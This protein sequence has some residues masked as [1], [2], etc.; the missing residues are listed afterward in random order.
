VKTYGGDKVEGEIIAYIFFGSPSFSASLADRLRFLSLP[1]DISKKEDITRLAAEIKKREGGLHI[2]VRCLLSLLSSPFTHSFPL[3]Q[4]NNAGIA[5]PKTKELAD[6]EKLS[7]E[8]LTKKLFEEEQ[9]G[10]NDV[11]QTN[12]QSIYYVT[13]AFLPL[14]EAFTFGKDPAGRAIYEK[15]QSVVC[16]FFLHFLL[17]LCLSVDEADSHPFFSSP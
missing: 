10:W 2:L 8:E 11:F 6:K 15:Y 16:V 13:L 9:Q 1:G 5:G 7:T 3:R 17:P 4:F 14:L 12:V